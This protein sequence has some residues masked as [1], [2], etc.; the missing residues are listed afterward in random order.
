G[1]PAS[2]PCWAH[3]NRRCCLRRSLHRQQ[4][5]RAGRAET[6]HVGH[7]DL[8]VRNLPLFRTV[9]LSEMPHDFADI[10][11]AGCAQRMTLGEQATR[12]VDRRL[13]AEVGMH[14]ATLVDKLAGL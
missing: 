11:D 9:I 2:G 12:N 1:P 10:R 5:N 14:A 13:A 6:D 4:M 3:C 8:S 7:A